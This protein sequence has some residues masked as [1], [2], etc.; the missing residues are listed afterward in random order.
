[1]TAT[2]L[3]KKYSIS[4]YIEGQIRVPNAKKL[5]QKTRDMLI[6]AKPEI[7]AELQRREQE[8]TE[9]KVAKLAEQEGERQAIL[10]GQ[11]LIQVR[12]HDGEHL[13]GWEVFGPAASILAGL[14]IAK[15]ITYWGYH[16]NSNIIETL[17]QEFTYQQAVEYMRPAVEAKKE[18][19]KKKDAERQAKFDEARET[20]KPV[21][22]RKWST[23]CCDPREECSMD[24]HNELAMPDGTVKHDWCHTY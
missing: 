23:G 11:K 3:I 7:I 21:L 12:Y 10:S 22:L 6:A 14:G 18:A 2:E 8:E 24:I 9:R 13:S 15:E 19:Q 1:M 16:I 4:L 5:S 20:G 17:G